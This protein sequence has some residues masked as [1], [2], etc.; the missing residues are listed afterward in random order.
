[1]DHIIVDPYSR[2]LMGEHNMTHERTQ[3]IAI[4]ISGKSPVLSMKTTS[5]LDL[6]TNILCMVLGLLLS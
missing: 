4:P 6:S 5:F 2:I 1:M 3:I